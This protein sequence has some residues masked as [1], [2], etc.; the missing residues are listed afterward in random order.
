MDYPYSEYANNVIQHYELK[1]K[2]ANEHGDK[3]CPNCGG[4]DRFFINEHNGLLKHHCRQ[5]CDDLERLKAMQRDGALPERTITSA[6]PYH[7]KKK[8]PLLA[9]R[10]EG[11]TVVVPLF[12]VLTGE[13]RGQQEIYPNSRKKFS[14][15]MKKLNAGAFYWR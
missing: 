10:L 2:T 9:A 1:R 3:P 15:G 5:R 8:L 14:T 6:V 7:Q 12:D 11:E 4:I 13:Q